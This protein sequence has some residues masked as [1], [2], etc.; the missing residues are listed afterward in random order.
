MK[1]SLIIQIAKDIHDI[2]TD[3]P[4][5]ETCLLQDKEKKICPYEYIF[6]SMPRDWVFGGDDNA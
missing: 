1:S 3:K 2:C 5:C 4:D 6:G